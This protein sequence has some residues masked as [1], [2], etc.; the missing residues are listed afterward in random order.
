VEEEEVAEEVSDEEWEA[1]EEKS[2]VC[3]CRES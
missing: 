1:E 3:E 2:G